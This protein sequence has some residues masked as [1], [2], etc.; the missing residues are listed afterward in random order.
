MQRHPSENAACFYYYVRHRSIV[1]FPAMLPLK[2]GR[3]SLRQSSDQC[4]MKLYSLKKIKHLFEGPD[5][6]N[7]VWRYSS[8]SHDWKQWTLFAHTRPKNRRITYAKVNMHISLLTSK[9][10]G[11]CFKYLISSLNTTHVTVHMGNARY[12]LL[13]QW[14]PVFPYG[15]PVR[16]IPRPVNNL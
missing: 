7:L 9:I 5:S 11:V 10:N 16:S 2:H 1:L 3:V 15:F 4:V 13:K 14:A 6:L 8:L 12:G